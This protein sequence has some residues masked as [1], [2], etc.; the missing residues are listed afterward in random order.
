MNGDSIRREFL[1]FFKKKNHQV[2]PSASLI[3]HGDSTLLFTS[4]GMVPFKDQFFGKGLTDDNR[5]AA[6]CQ[7]CLR[8]TDLESVGRTSRHQTF[9]EMLGNFSFGDYFKREAI[10][11][12]WEFVTEVLKFDQSRLYVSIFESDEETFEIWSKEIGIDPKR[13]V[14]LGEK[15]NFWKMGDTGPCG[16]CSEIYIDMGES[17][18]CKKPDCFVGCSCDRYIEFWNLV[19]TQYNRKEDGTLEPLPRTNIDTGMGLER[20]ASIAQGVTTNFDTD[21]IRPIITFIEDLANVDYGYY[22]DKDVSFRIIA[23]H[24]RAVTIAMSD[25]IF[26]SNEGRGYV[27]RRLMR[28]AIRHGKLLGIN[29]SFMHK[30]VAVV[31]SILKNGYPEITRQRESLTKM[32]RAEEEKFQQ[33]LDHGCRILDEIM[34]KKAETKQDISG[35]EA[36]MLFD[37]YGFPL[38]LTLEIAREKN[39]SVN[40]DEFNASM[41]SQRE[42]A[43]SKSSHISAAKESGAATLYDELLASS[44]R[45]QFLGYERE[46]SD[47]AVV[48]ISKEGR[49]VSSAST[50][51]EI[52]IILD[53]TPF[54]GESGGQVGDSGALFNDVATLE[55]SS[56]YKPNAQLFAHV[57]RVVSGEIKAGD[58][59]TA[60]VND[61]SRMKI[62]AAHTAT[63]ILHAALRSALGE[64]VKQAGSK[65]EQ[66]RLR[67]DFTHF[68]AV[69]P[70][71]LKAIENRVNDVIR[72]CMGVATKVSTLEDA[73]KEGAMALF[74]E[75][76]GDTVRVVSVGN[77]SKELCG[78]THVSNSGQ[79]GLVK[80]L[81]ETALAAGVR[82]IEALVAE[83]AL[84][85]LKEVED[86][87]KNISSLLKCPVVEVEEAINKMQAAFKGV[88]KENVSLK[89]QLA[90]IKAKTLA[91]NAHSIG[92]YKVIVSTLDGLSDEDLRGV[93][94]I[95]LERVKSGV[96]ILSSK[97]EPKVIFSGKAS[98]DAVKAGIH[99]GK[100]IGEV[101]K[102]CGGGGGGKPNMAM[103]G[104]KNPE[105]V[106]EALKFAAKTITAALS[107]KQNSIVD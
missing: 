69:D 44:A 64:H 36:F 35:A 28:R 54:Y 9:F 21:L 91:D 98:E 41:E 104:G 100:L 58:K 96:V 76:Y 78:G 53:K 90:T 99:V 95:L 80:I 26:P 70:E 68:E 88:E 22:E 59:I 48:F 86:K 4:A 30:L 82:R 72:G 94:D 81:S 15:D 83:E 49:K 97:M 52:E 18:G 56:V 42:R 77:Y 79:I 87:V 106:S 32:V 20:V 75:K 55:V 47:A 66:G 27:I 43:R 61:I 60:K 92:G 62:R 37:T 8:E 89:R 1:N 57:C 85:Y 23:D 31:I 7:K 102:I 13:I 11:W 63:H 34:V 71:V 73:Q 46:Q 105:M 101:A 67:F 39:M 107:P 6:S 40:V 24:A 103:A 93:C 29:S 14:R 38:E 51:D 25:G 84:N 19:F 16:P 17:R 50:G 3:P 74:D 33:T 12:A 2:K 45:T 65:V 5:R 10:T